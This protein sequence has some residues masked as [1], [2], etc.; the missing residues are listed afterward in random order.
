MQR[1]TVAV[2]VN[3]AFNVV[4]KITRPC[5]LPHRIVRPSAST[6]PTEP[7]NV[8]RHSSSVDPHAAPQQ[9]ALPRPGGDR[10][11][12]RPSPPGLRH[13]LVLELADDDVRARQHAVLRTRLFDRPPRFRSSAYDSVCWL[14][15]SSAACGVSV[16]ETHATPW[17]TGTARKVRS[18][19]PSQISTMT[20]RFATFAVVVLVVFTAAMPASAAACCQTRSMMAAMHGT[21]PCCNHC[22]ITSAENQAQQNSNAVTAPAPTLPPLAVAV[23]AAAAP[24]A[25]APSA[26]V[27]TTVPNSAASPP[28][29]FLLNEQFRI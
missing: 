2:D 4:L 22:K 17:N 15:H 18:I 13:R 25:T 7:A 3:T 1:I 16:T 20:R 26:V 21:M 6:F 12:R 10:R 8:V 27:Q 28:S 29:P 19:V 11:A 14:P 24:Q 23:I 5:G 9:S